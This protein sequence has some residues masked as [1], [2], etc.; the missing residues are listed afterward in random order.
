MTGKKKGKRSGGTAGLDGDAALALTNEGQEAV[1]LGVRVEL[2]LRPLQSLTDVQLGVEEQPVGALELGL[3]VLRE[4]STVE[5]HRVQAEER[6]RNPGRLHVGGHVLL[7]T[8]AAADER[9]RPDA[10]EL[11]DRS[12]STHDALLVDGHVPR[13]AYRV[14]EDHPVPD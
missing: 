2:A 6:R 11:V 9:V 14:A 3:H 13:E 8:R 1:D 12:H 10:D 7:D 4:A 5:P